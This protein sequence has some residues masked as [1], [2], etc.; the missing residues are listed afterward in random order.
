MN[1][2]QQ[3]LETIS[4]Q[5][6]HH[7]VKN[8]ETIIQLSAVNIHLT[9]AQSM[10]N[11]KTLLDYQVTTGKTFHAVA[12]HATARTAV[13]TLSLYQADTADATTL[14]KLQ[15]ITQITV[16]EEYTIPLHFEIASGKFITTKYDV[17]NSLAKLIIIGYEK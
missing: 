7:P 2:K 12:F 14:L 1:Y 13:G 3:H 5:I 9:V 10:T 8:D 17:A 11:D 4:S 15:Q 6:H 16:N